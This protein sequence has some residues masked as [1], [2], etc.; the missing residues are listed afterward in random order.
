MDEV[1]QSTQYRT[2]NRGVEQD[3]LSPLVM[4]TQAYHGMWHEN[5]YDRKKA[6]MYFFLKSYL[7]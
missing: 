6:E 2:Q 1:T 5:I 7:G 4:K 3:F